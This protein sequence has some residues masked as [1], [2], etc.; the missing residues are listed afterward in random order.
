MN[1]IYCVACVMKANDELPATRRMD[2]LTIRGKARKNC[3]LTYR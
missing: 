2:V 3:N 1:Y